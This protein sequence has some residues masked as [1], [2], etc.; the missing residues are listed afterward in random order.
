MKTGILISYKELRKVNPRAARLAV[1]EYLSGSGHNIAEAARTFG[2]NRPVVYDILRKEREGDLSDRSRAPKNQP[3]KT[4]AETEA[5]VLEVKNQ[6]RLGAKRLSRHLKKY[7]ELSVPYGTIR[8]ILR[9]NREK[10][11][12]PHH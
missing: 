11:K 1:L 10:I 4:P 7:E 2:I 3:R 9:R 12:Y 8:H 5:K 6:T